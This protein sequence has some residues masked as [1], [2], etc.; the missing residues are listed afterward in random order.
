MLLITTPSIKESL[1]SCTVCMSHMLPEVL[2]PKMT[3]LNMHFLHCSFVDGET[4]FTVGKP[5][6]K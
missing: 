2:Y 5:Y 4:K 6:A 3:V 1:S